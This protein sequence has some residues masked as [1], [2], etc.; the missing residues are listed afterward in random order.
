MRLP[1]F[2]P[3]KIIHNRIIQY[4]CNRNFLKMNFR[5]PALAFIPALILSG[6]AVEEDTVANQDEKMY[7]EAW[8]HIHY[9]EAELSGIGTYI[10][11][12]TPADEEGK[13]V[14]MPCYARVTYTVRDMSGNISSTS[15]STIAK[16]TGNFNKSYYYGPRVWS[17]W[18]NSLNKGLEDMV[19]G[20]RE[21]DERM[22]LIPGWTQ[23]YQRYGSEEEY[24]DNVTGNSHQIYT[25]KIDEV[26]DDI[27]EWQIDT[28]ENY[29]RKAWPGETP[30]SLYRGFYYRTS[31]ETPGTGEAAD[32]HK[33]TTIYIN[34]TGWLLNG[35]VFD[36][37]KERVA[38]DNNIYSSSKTY[39][40]MEVQMAEDS[41]S[42]QLDGNDIIAGF[43]R[44]IW[45]M[46]PMEKGTGLFWSAYGYGTS[47]SGSLI[48]EYAPLVFEIEI[49]ENPDGE[50]E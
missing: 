11:R 40:P 21:G 49:V 44:T 39:A 34:Y 28:I 22:A 3:E 48:P 37:T 12:D 29:Y 30:Y 1:A 42:V 5:V 7:V 16:Q 46:K 6:C 15:D 18:D 41:T 43:A 26:V 31:P 38:K 23:T 14:T 36:T 27:M 32:L 33:D 17:V 4:F 9:P 13:E 20:M 19:V 25:V 47:G 8:L 10:L 50:E 2:N 45:Q 24:L 35:Q